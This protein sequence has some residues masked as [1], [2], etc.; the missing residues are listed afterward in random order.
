MALSYAA[1][2]VFTAHPSIWAEVFAFGRV[3]SPL[4]VLVGLDGFRTRSAAAV[5]PLALTAPRIG[6]QIAPQLLA[7]ARALLP[8]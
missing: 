2:A 7:I 5:L 1:L 4:I 3:F 8:G 6:L